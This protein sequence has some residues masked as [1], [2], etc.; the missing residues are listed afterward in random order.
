MASKIISNCQFENPGILSMQIVDMYSFAIDK[1]N[2]RERD[3]SLISRV[4]IKSV[5]KRMFLYKCTLYNNSWPFFRR[6][7]VYLS[8]N[9]GSDDHFEVLNRFYL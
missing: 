9:I 6:M 3:A 1:H 4:D 2:P 5:Y 7:C 8:Q